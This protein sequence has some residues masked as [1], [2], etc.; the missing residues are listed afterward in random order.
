VSPAARAGAL[1]VLLAAAAPAR[2]SDTTVPRDA[3]ALFVFTLED[4]RAAAP[5][6]A[7]AGPLPVGSLAKPFV[8]RAWV[9]AHPGMPMPVLRC[10]PASHCWS[11]SGHGTL[12]LVRATAVSCNTYFRALA[13]ATPPAALAASLRAA[14]LLPPDPLD[15]DQ[16]IGLPGSSGLVSAEPAAVLRAYAALVREPW[17]GAEPVR[18]E[19][20]AGLRDSAREGTA[21]GLAGFGFHAKTGTVPALD[22]RPL[23][24]SGWAVAV[25]E[26]GRG[27]LGL[28]TP[29]TGREAARALAGRL[30]GSARAT[31]A[32]PAPAPRAAASPL[33]RVALFDALAPRQARARNAGQAPVSTSRGFVGPGGALELRPGDRLASGDWE[34]ALPGSGLRRLVRGVVRVDAG[35]R[36][37][38][39]LRAELSPPEYVAGVIA[40]ELPSADAA[41]RLALGAA[42]LRFLAEGPRHGDADVCD[43]T[44]CA[45]FVGRGPRAAWPSPG[46]ALLPGPAGGEPAPGAPAFDEETWRRV[47]DA[48]RQ[49]GPARWT[50]HCGGEPLSA[51]AVWGGPDRTVYRCPLHGPSDRADWSRAWSREDV[52]RALGG[53]VDELRVAAQDGLWLLVG[54]RDG[55][56]LRLT[57]DEAHAR[58]AGVLGW[59]ALPS[60]ADR[61]V[62][63]RDGFRATGRGLGH[64][65]GLCLGAADGGAS[66]PLLD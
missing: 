64:R 22:G 60:P 12:G 56:P 44:H 11:A 25:D 51:H 23:T 19:L 17:N 49:P 14:G 8:A 62:R 16:A 26:S 47:A 18:R 34:L 7:P 3:P 6:G 15:A 2:A 66:R 43:L 31:G 48:A 42:V 21:S 58:L 10:S 57:W 39:K 1:A 29:G 38:L 40:A 53:R 35:P 13:A 27:F 63:E 36:D 28:L 30:R 32:W 46:R 54:L 50:S 41:S 65:V 37:V 9:L 33:V 59:G 20:L 4:G 5:P 52:D 55:A 61:V 45:F 24:T